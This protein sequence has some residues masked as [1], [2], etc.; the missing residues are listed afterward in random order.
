MCSFTFLVLIFFQCQVRCQ[1][2]DI[3]NLKSM[4]FSSTH[5]PKIVLLDNDTVARRYEGGCYSVCFSDQPLPV[6]ETLHFNITE[7]E[8]GWLANLNV[9]IIYKSPDSFLPGSLVL[10][11]ANVSA[12]L[13]DT[14]VFIFERFYSSD[15]VYSFRVD[16]A[17]IAYLSP[18]V[19]NDDV[20]FTEFD[21]N[22]T[23]WVIFN[24]FGDSKAVKLLGLS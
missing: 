14:K 16:E 18:N 23:F 9:G 7:I 5:G 2:S 6:G 21:V 17:G 8:M 22:R 24:I 1:W 20:I 12:S 13:P 19:T 11:D 4:K 10:C 3:D 15:N